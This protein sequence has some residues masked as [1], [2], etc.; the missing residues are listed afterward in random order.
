[1]AVADTLALASNRVTE[2]D[3]PRAI[4]LS[5]L[6]LGDSVF[7][8]RRSAGRSMAQVHLAALEALCSQWIGS[9]SIKA[10]VYAAEAATWIPHDDERTLD[11]A[12]QRKLRYDPER[13]VREAAR[14]S[15]ED[16]QRREAAVELRGL[17]TDS[18]IE[19][20]NDWVL[21]RYAISMALANIGDDFDARHLRN[22]IARGQLAPPI[23]R[24]FTQILEGLDK[25]WRETTRKWPEPWLPWRGSVEQLDGEI[26]VGGQKSNCRFSLWQTLPENDDEYRSWGGAIF[27]HDAP[28]WW[29]EK[30]MFSSDNGPIKILIPGRLSAEAHLVNTGT[31]GTIISGTGRY[32]DLTL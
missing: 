11:N 30:V 10:R 17:L 19:N 16:L 12:V 2:S 24:F 18:T 15:R 25:Q 27:P 3:K 32:P 14:R 5:R 8:V 7:A 21:R 20:I 22:F 6:L 28:S 23:H 29:A 31:D 9:G 1:V 13:Q 26:L 4:E